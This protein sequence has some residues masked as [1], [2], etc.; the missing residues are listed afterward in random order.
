M[1]GIPEFNYAA[2]HY[3]ATALRGQ[4]IEVI[5]PAE[6]HGDDDT[7]GDHSWEWYLRAALK[8]VLECDEIVLLPGWEQS[9]G[10]RLEKHVAE[11]LG[12]RVTEWAATG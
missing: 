8:A 3:A 10:A 2:F 6:L 11:Q 9:R 12:M 7:G 4:G 1:T 5:N